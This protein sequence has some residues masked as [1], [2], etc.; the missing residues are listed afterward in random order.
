MPVAA[1]STPSKARRTTTRKPRT[2]KKATAKSVAPVAPVKTPVVK[3][4]KVTAPPQSKLTLADYRED[5]QARVRIHN[6]EVNALWQDIKKGYQTA[7][8]FVDKAVN[9]V[10]ESYKREF[11][12]N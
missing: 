7:K 2:T 10:Q 1:K 12:T 6:Y 4:V 11:G 3:E 9:Y 8:P 5:F